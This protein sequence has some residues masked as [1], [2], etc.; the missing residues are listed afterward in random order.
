MQYAKANAKD[1]VLYHSIYMAF[2]KRQNY[3]DGE[4]WSPWFPGVRLVRELTAKET[5]GGDG[6]VLSFDWNAYL[7]CQNSLNYTVKRVSFILCKFSLNKPDFKKNKKKIFRIYALM[8]KVV[9]GIWLS[10]IG[11]LRCI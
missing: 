7:L 11:K 1:Y 5:F 9:H 4:Q 8:W 2:W 6:N 10:E 3:R